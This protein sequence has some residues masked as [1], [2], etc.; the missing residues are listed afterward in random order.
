MLVWRCSVLLT[1]L[2][3]FLALQKAAPIVYKYLGI[4][5]GVYPTTTTNPTLLKI[6]ENIDKTISNIYPSPRNSYFRPSLPLTTMHITVLSLLL[7]GSGLLGTATAQTPTSSATASA[8]SSGPLESCS[9]IVVDSITVEDT[10]LVCCKELELAVAGLGTGVGINCTCLLFHFPAW[11]PATIVL[12][13]KP[14][15]MT[16]RVMPR[17]KICLNNVFR[18]YFGTIPGPEPSEGCY[19]LAAPRR[20]T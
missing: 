11:S 2:E 14:L 1:A 5:L 16:A 20:V 6:L 12:D 9:P 17:W 10:T 15:L 18:T 19:A 7:A 4:S 8:V 13:G 3:L